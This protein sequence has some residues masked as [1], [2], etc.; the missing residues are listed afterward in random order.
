MVQNIPIEASR[1]QIIK[2]ATA[3]DEDLCQ[4]QNII[5]T[6]SGWPDNKSNVPLELHEYWI[7]RDELSVAHGLIL[8][9][10]RIVIPR[11]LCS[12]MLRLLHV[13]HFSV[14]KTTRKARGAVYWLSDQALIL[15]SRI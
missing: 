7:C 11:E 9:G 13:R 14:E 2:T 5:L 15:R 4:L 10:D 12:T 1:L 6:N 3:T 8:R